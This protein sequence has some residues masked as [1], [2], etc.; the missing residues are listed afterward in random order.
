MARTETAAADATAELS[1]QELQAQI[2]TLKSDIA[3]LTAAVG[4][5]GKAQSEAL[6]AQARAGLRTVAGKGAE[7]VSAAQDYAVQTYAQGEDYVRAHPA[8]SVGMAAGLG[9]LVGLVAARR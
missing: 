7:Q 8:S 4:R 1:T 2:A 5:F 9:F 3:E 6:A